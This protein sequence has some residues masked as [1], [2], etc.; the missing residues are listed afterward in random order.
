MD[1]I[2]IIEKQLP[3]LESVLSAVSKWSTEIEPQQQRLIVLGGS[4]LSIHH[5]IYPRHAQIEL[6]ALIS[7]NIGADFPEI[8]LRHTRWSLLSMGDSRQ[9]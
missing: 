6:I 5:V 8:P 1:E 4:N 3:C 7:N 9:E 2:L